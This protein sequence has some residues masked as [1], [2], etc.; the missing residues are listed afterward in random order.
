MMISIEEQILDK[1][2]TCRDIAF[3][4]ISVE[5]ASKL[6]DLF[7]TSFNLNVARDLE[8]E[9][10]SISQAQRYIDTAVSGMIHAIWQSSELITHIQLFL[11]WENRDFSAEIT[12]FP[13]DIIQER[14]SMERFYQ[15]LEPI[16]QA[17]NSEKFYV[18]YE[19]A[20][21]NIGDTGK[22]SG[23]IF[24]HE[25]FNRWAANIKGASS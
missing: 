13:D 19:N 4:I 1:D 15:F 2:G 21:W 16:V 11:D 8:G 24:S 10:L 18:R 3:P 6:L 25:E 7:A 22:G 9:T 5:G 12:F 14:F 20:S 23:V 17:A